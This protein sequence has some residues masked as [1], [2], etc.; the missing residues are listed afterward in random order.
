MNSTGA[1]QCRQV[2][3]QRTQRPLSGRKA[4]WTPQHAQGC[5]TG[6][7]VRAQWQRA[8]VTLGFA[9]PAATALAVPDPVRH[10]RSAA[11]TGPAV[12]SAHR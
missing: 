3:E 11:S 12:T 2:R 9:Y 4:R 10:V 8:Q 7:C 6:A 5:L 1:S